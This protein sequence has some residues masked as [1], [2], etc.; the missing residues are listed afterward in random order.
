MGLK[1]KI[2]IDHKIKPHLIDFKGWSINDLAEKMSLT[3]Q[4]VSQTLNGKIEPSMRF[5]KK[6]IEVTKLDIK[7]ILFVK[8][9]VK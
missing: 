7:D 3:K 8:W 2:L 6:L 5:T 9:E 1:A 4:Q